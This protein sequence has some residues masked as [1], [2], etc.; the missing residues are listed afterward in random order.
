LNRLNIL[1]VVLACSL[2]SSAHVLKGVVQHA[3]TNKPAAGDEVTLNQPGQNG[4]QEVG[5]AKTNARGEFQ[6]KLPDPAAGY[7]ILVNHQKAPYS[8]IV[9]PGAAAAPACRSAARRRGCGG[10]SCA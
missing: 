2:A 6:F 1:I 4:M 3:T 10:A 9:K 7:V 5:K 8:Y